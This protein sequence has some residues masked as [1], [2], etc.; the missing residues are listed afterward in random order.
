[1]HNVLS[2]S[3]EVGVP[4]A[5]LSGHPLIRVA[6]LERLNTAGAIGRLECCVGSEESLYPKEL[7]CMEGDARKEGSSTEHYA[8]V[9]EGCLVRDKPAFHGPFSLI[10]W[11][12]QQNSSFWHAYRSPL[13]HDEPA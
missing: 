11:R 1:M 3:F 5:T 8:G 6:V 2:R 12:E 9:K 4:A 10:H 13:F 7:R